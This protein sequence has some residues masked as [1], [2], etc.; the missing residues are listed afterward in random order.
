M[1]KKFI[2]DLD[3]FVELSSNFLAENMHKASYILIQARVTF[4]YRNRPGCGKLYVTNDNKCFKYK[5]TK[6]SDL[7]NI[8]S[9]FK[10]LLHMMANKPIQIESKI[11]IYPR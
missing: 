5:F 1:K 2:Q 6:R 4:K 9:Y 8:D 10:S 11:F 3:N 7:D